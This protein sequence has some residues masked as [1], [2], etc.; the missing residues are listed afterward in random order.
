MKQSFLRDHIPQFESDDN[1][2]LVEC[3]LIMGINSLLDMEG[4]ISRGSARPLRAYVGR[5]E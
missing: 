1:E 5:R 4:P 2:E 3:L